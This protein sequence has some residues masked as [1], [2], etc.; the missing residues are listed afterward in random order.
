MNDHCSGAVVVLDIALLGFC[1]SPHERE[2]L[3]RSCLDSSGE[4]VAFVSCERPYFEEF[5]SDEVQIRKVAVRLVFELFWGGWISTNHAN[6]EEII[7]SE[8]YFILCFAIL[9]I[10]L[11]FWFRARS[12]VPSFR[13]GVVFT[14]QSTI[15]LGRRWNI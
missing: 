13:R 15:S 1:R 8:V 11:H 4:C 2:V 6:M 12:A 10:Q 3:R 5:S 7:G 14:P 9:H